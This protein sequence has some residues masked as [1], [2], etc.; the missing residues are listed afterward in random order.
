MPLLSNLREKF[1][2]FPTIDVDGCRADLQCL[3]FCPHDVFEWDAKT[4][5][6]IVAHPLRCLPGC[7]ICVQG[8]DTGAISLPTKREFQE[9]LKRLRDAEN[10]PHTLPHF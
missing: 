2:W 4:G 9:T 1:P 10:K 6:P 7:E 8:C 5:R 3:N